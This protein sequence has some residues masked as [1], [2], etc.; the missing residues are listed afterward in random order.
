MWRC[1]PH[2]LRFLVNSILA[3]L[4]GV[5]LILVF[6]RFNLTWLAPVALAPLLIACA[7]ESRWKWRF[8]NGWAAGFVFWFGVCYWI[9][10][11]LEVH[12]GL[13]RWGGW[14]TFTLFAMLKGLHMALFSTFAGYL[15]PTPWAIP[16]V[17]ALW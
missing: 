6:P 10:F 12:G 2:P 11:V 16:A 14:A 7:R 4:S 1:A 13:G 9:Q 3:L 17:A 8:L 15:L 5:L